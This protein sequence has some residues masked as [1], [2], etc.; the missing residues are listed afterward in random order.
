MRTGMSA[1]VIKVGN[2][3]KTFAEEL[4]EASSDGWRL[5]SWKVILE[6]GCGYIYFAVLER[7]PN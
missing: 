5:Q 4:N 1:E 7:D 3:P 2:G 6:P